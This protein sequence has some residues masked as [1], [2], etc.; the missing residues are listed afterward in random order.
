M[1]ILEAM[2]S[3]GIFFVS[4]IALLCYCFGHVLAL[5]WCRGELMSLTRL[6]F[7]LVLIV[8]IFVYAAGN[9]IDVSRRT[10]A[11]TIQQVQEAR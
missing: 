7:W 9:Y 2:Y 5:R 4:H 1:P 8:T 3:P 6:I 10:L 11:H